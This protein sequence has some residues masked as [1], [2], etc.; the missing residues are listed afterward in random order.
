MLHSKPPMLPR[1]SIFRVFIAGSAKQCLAFWRFMYQSKDLYN[2]GGFY[3]VATPAWYVS[4][5]GL[6]SIFGMPSNLP[7]AKVKSRSEGNGYVL[8]RY[9]QHLLPLNRKCNNI[10]PA[11][12]C[13]QGP[14]T[15]K[16][17]SH[18]SARPQAYHLNIAR[19]NAIRTS[20]YEGRT[21]MATL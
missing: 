15:S 1:F 8:F 16:D 7:Q 21:A 6:M 12:S 3:L 13:C 17:R 18:C 9:F 11:A 5:S 4:K 14:N 2:I 20:K 19:W 10:R